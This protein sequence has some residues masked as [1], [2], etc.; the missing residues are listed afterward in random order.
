MRMSGRKI[1]HRPPVGCTDD[2]MSRLALGIGWRPELSGFIVARDDLDFVEILAEAFPPERPLPLGLERLLERKQPVIPH[3]VGLSLGGAERPERRRLAR[4][5]GLAERVSA[6]IV[7]EHVAFVR[8]GGVEAG[9]LL[10]VPRTWQSLKVIAENVRIAQDQ[11]PVPLVLEHV[12]AVLEWPEAELDEADFLT[13]LLARTDALLLLDVANL[14]AN[15]ANYGV[16]PLA[17]LSRVPLERVAYVHVAGGT[18]EDGVYV[19]T[20]AHPV[21]TGV[22]TLL[23]EAIGRGARPAVMLE[24]DDRFASDAELGREL[25]A[26]RLAGRV[27]E[28]RS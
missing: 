13:E 19:D 3:G 11:L 15:T 16:D 8:A 17:F 23:R 6:P 27:Q 9:H 24:R 25:N 21:P 14:Y 2:G 18:I 7:S 4:L 12:A 28:V 5:A 10:P 20:H 22:L 1:S 26:I